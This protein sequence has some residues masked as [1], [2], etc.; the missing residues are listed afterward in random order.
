MV[1]K[2]VSFE[3]LKVNNLLVTIVR[4]ECRVV[5]ISLSGIVLLYIALCF[6]S[7]LLLNILLFRYSTCV[8]LLCCFQLVF[9]FLFFKSD[10]GKDFPYSCELVS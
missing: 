8:V 3:T 2:A 4:R 7:F 1:S 5:D 6:V 9:I 10:V